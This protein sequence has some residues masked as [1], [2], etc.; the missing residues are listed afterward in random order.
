MEIIKGIH[1][2]KAIITLTTIHY[3]AFSIS[4][5][6]I[7]LKQNPDFIKEEAKFPPTKKSQLITFLGDSSPIPLLKIT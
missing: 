7:L 2:G 3:Q 1:K 5:N 6:P 4:L